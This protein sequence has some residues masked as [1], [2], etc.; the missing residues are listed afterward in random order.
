M[1]IIELPLG[2]LQVRVKGVFWHPLELCQPNLCHAPEAF[3]AVDMVP[4]TGELVLRVV[5]NDNA[6][7]HKVDPPVV[8]APDITVD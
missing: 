6:H 2:F 4:P 1:A 7:T 5:E 8:A 3:N